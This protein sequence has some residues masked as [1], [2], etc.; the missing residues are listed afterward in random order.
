MTLFKSILNHFSKGMEKKVM[1]QITDSSNFHIWASGRLAS[2]DVDARWD[3]LCELN[4]QYEGSIQAV[5]DAGYSAKDI[6]DSVHLWA[7]V[8]KDSCTPF[9]D[10]Y[11][12][13][14]TIVYKESVENNYISFETAQHKV[15]RQNARPEDV[16][17]LLSPDDQVWFRWAYQL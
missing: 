1:K 11:S 15:R 5:L 13:L 7:V 10:D 3:A 17:K 9:I 12:K 16:V 6:L 8:R 2:C 14:A 4:H